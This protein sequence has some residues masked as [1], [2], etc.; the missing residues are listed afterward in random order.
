MPDFYTIFSQ[1]KAIIPIY[2]SAKAT[3]NN[4]NTLSIIYLLFF[5][6][7][8][9]VRYPA[10]KIDLGLLP[11]QLLLTST[12][13]ILLLL[14]FNTILKKK[15]KVNSAFFKLKPIWFFGTFALITLSSFF[16]AITVVESYITIGKMAI[17]FAF[18]VLTTLLFITEKINLNTILKGL[19]VFALISSGQAAFK[20]IEALGKGEFWG[21][22]YIVNGLYYH[23][24]LLSSILMLGLPFM[25]LAH[26]NLSKLWQNIALVVLIISLIDILLLRTRGVLLALVVASFATTAA[27]FITRKEEN[28]LTSKNKKLLGLIGGTML[29]AIAVVVSRP[30]Q[31]SNIGDPETINNRFYFWQTS[32]EMFKEN[33]LL[34]VGGNNWKIHFPQ[35][36]LEEMNYSVA[37]GVTQ[38]QRPHNDYLWVLA[39]FGI[40]GFVLYI[41]FFLSM[42]ICLFTLLK[43]GDSSKHGYYLTLLFGIIS[44]MSFAFGDF[45]MER[46]GHQVL[47]LLLFALVLKDYYMLKVNSEEKA[48]TIH[49]ASLL[50]IVVP[51]LFSFII[52]S[53]RL[54]GEKNV[55]DVMKYN[56]EKNAFKIVTAADKTINPYYNM[57]YTGIPIYYYRGKGYL[58]QANTRN[59]VNQG[60]LTKAKEDLLT[61]NELNPNNIIVLNQLANFYKLNNQIDKA[62]EV[63][64]EA[65]EISPHYTQAL[66]DVAEIH[67]RQ[68]NYTEAFNAIVKVDPRDIVKPK[69]Q[70][71]IP[72]IMQGY[73]QE[74]PSEAAKVNADARKPKYL[75]YAYRVL[76]NKTN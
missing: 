15:V 18:F 24:N 1:T 73:L 16:T 6:L 19:V 43:K 68:K 74:N 64:N 48:S 58:F 72:P 38:M 59:G 31:V 33:P 46:I 41:A 5:A 67:L 21:D 75:E 37:N 11:R 47:L 61:A 44:Y 4:T 49:P 42:L 26:K 23:K 51:V 14:I 12:V 27:Y 28:K 22:V 66:L 52:S 35:Y 53:N 13:A 25:Y 62:L 63:Y 70:G 57:D 29:I 55:T 20:I 30:G 7:F 69:M 65:L 71:M 76:R 32:I 45:P 10:L 2:M 36:G 3:K 54:Q 60:L 8:P 56:K 50:L 17:L 9:I 34:G 39:E 40:V